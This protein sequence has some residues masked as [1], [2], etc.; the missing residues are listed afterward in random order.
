MSAYTK[1]DCK[2]DPKVGGKFAHFGGSIEGYFT[3]L[4]FI[5][6]CFRFSATCD[7]VCLGAE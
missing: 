1:T 2:I 5:S 7:S 4:V 6:F 3:E